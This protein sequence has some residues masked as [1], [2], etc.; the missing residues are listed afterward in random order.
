MN[1]FFNRLDALRQ[2]P[3][4]F[5]LAMIL[6][7]LMPLGLAPLTWWPVALLAFGLFSQLLHEQ[8]ARRAARLC[9]AF[10]CGLWLHGGSW[11]LVSMHDYGSTPWPLAL[12]M[13]AA[14]AAGMATLFYPLGWLY[15]RARLDKLG[16]LTLPILFALGEWLR[17]WLLTGFP[18]LMMGYGFIDTPLAGWAPVL[19]IYGVSMAAG[20]TGAAI[21]V[22]LRQGRKAYA[23]LL[24]LLVIWAAGAGLN[25]VSWTHINKNKPFTVS[26]IQGNIPQEDKWALEWRDKTVQIYRDLS[27]KEWGRDLVLWPE[28]AVPMFAHE[29]Q[30]VL[31]SI[32]NDALKGDSAFVTGIPFAT[33]NKARTG[34]LFYNSI[35]AMGDGFGL[36][37]KQQ[38]V[39]IGEYIPFEAW[40]RG[41]IPFFDLPMS[42]FSWGPANQRPLVVKEYNMAPFICY[43][44]AYPSLVQRMSVPADFLATISNDGWFGHSI[45][46]VQHF[47]MVR[48]RAKENGRYIIRATNNGIT[49]FIDEHGQ[50]VSEAPEF[51]RTVLRGVVYPATGL[52]PWQRAGVYPFLLISALVLLAGWR[53]GRQRRQ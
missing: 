52:T 23:P 38:L 8:N 47:Q 44:I 4:T 45:G 48:M 5:W 26:L 18:W 33:W 31:T 9:Y 24:T 3:A 46:P 29:A 14:V 15:G 32:E 25:Q 36:Y 20:I 21:F 7:A 22:I 1:S 13:L 30:D 37:F 43:E 42:S 10:G 28:A 11:L 49:A 40:L 50:V 17:S 2:G 41:A 6:G 35:A 12:L 16:W 27:A 53:C 39:P 34:V 51:T 19:G